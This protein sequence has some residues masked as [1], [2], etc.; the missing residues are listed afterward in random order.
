MT[1]AELE[2]ALGL[3]KK[4][5]L[6]FNAKYYTDPEQGWHE[7]LM[8]HAYPQRSAS[9]Y[10]MPSYQSPVTGKWIDTPS[11]RRDDLARTSSR[12]WEGMDTEKQE[13]ARTKAATEAEMDKVS[14]QIAVES[15]KS[16][17]ETTRRIL[18]NT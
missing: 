8:M 15:F 6:E 9:V 14:E 3:D 11:Q 12:P 1:D 13:A 18:E 16:L 5:W 7:K 4:I 17:P 2:V 10:V